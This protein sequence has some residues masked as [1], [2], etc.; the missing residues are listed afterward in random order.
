MTIKITPKS[1]QSAQS[2]H[3]TTHLLCSVAVAGF[4][5]FALPAAA[6][7]AGASVSSPTSPPS[8]APAKA[9]KSARKPLAERLQAICSSADLNHDGSMSLEEF[10]QDIVQSWHNLSPDAT[11]HVQLADLAQVPHMGK[12]RLKRLAAIDRDGDGKLSF[13]EVVETRM[14]YFD[15]ADADQND[16]LSIQ[17]CVAHERQRRSSKP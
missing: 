6:Q 16:Q 11:G 1:A 4:L 9:Q 14:A 12:G 10:H 2:A 3:R 5:G 13:K 8:T 15:A 7:G 17:E